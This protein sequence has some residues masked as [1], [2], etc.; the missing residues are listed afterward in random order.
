M[1]HGRGSAFCRNTVS[2]FSGIRD[3]RRERISGFISEQI[4][5]L[6]VSKSI[7]RYV[8]E[9]Q[10]SQRPEKNLFCVPGFSGQGGVVGATFCNSLLHRIEQANVMLQSC[11]FQ[12][13]G[14]VND[15]RKKIGYDLVPTVKLLSIVSMN[16]TGFCDGKVSHLNADFNCLKSVHDIPQAH[17]PV[18]I[19]KQKPEADW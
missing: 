14:C 5:A 1:K 6:K 13:P 8:K 15:V 12:R 2:G 3:R 16:E 7:W 4:F 18:G 9:L 19:L 10:L 11:C 17:Q